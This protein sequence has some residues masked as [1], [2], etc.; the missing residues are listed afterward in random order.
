[1]MSCP[2]A[3]DARTDSAAADHVGEVG[4]LGL[5]E[6]GRNADRDR[7]ALGQP[8]EVGGGRDEA[9]LA[10][11]RAST[12]PGTSSTWLVPSVDPVD[13]PRSLISKPN[14]PE[15]APGHLDRQGKTHVSLA[16]DAA[17]LRRAGSAPATGPDRPPWTVPRVSES[18]SATRRC[19][20]RRRSYLAPMAFVPA[21]PRQAPVRTP[22]SKW[23]AAFAAPC[24]TFHI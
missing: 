21:V 4:I 2:G 6:R 15:P 11:S 1:M 18:A 10:R 22:S 16:D 23:P 3:G 17:W 19:A 24:E 14:H 20:V 8:G 9:L 12:S 7:V 5:V 13:R